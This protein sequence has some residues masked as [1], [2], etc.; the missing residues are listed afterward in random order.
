ML[1]SS[2]LGRCIRFPVTDVRVFAGRDSD[3]VRGI[4][5]AEGDSVISMAILRT[6]DASGPE[7]AAYLRH[8]SAM[9]RGR[10]RGG[11]RCRACAGG[12]R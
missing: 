4:R 7:R 12:G 1:L 10:Q 2:A 8:A 3:G 5:L 6:V 11:G 9:R